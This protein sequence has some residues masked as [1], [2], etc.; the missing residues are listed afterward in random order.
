[1]HH[2]FDAGHFIALGLASA[3]L[4]GVYRRW[5]TTRPRTK[6]VALAV[7]S[8]ALGSLLLPPDLSNMAQRIGG[9]Y[10]SIAQKILLA[11]STFAITLGVP[12]AHALGRLLARPWWRWLGMAMGGAI[13]ATH[14]RVLSEFYH[15]IHFW[16][17]AT[18]VTFFASA[19]AGAVLP[20]TLARVLANCTGPRIR[21]V[22]LAFLSV[23]AAISIGH[24]PP[25]AVAM[26]LVRNDGS[27]LP[28]FLF[29]LLHTPTALHKA[30]IPAEMK[31]WFEDRRNH[32]PVAPTTPPFM[33]DKPIVILATIDCARADIILSGKYDAQLPTLARLRDISTTFTHARATAS[34]TAS[35][36]AS[37][38]MGTYF[39]QQYWAPAK[40]RLE[41]YAE[42]SPRVPEI[43][44]GA[45]V[46][47]VT[48][49]GA[50]GLTPRFGVLRGFSESTNLQK[51]SRY[52]KAEELMT[53]ALARLKNR[54]N[55]ALFLYLHFLDAHAPYDRG[56]KTG[57]L[58]D[59]YISE[60]QLVD[61]Q[62]SR[63]VWHIQSTPLRDRTLLIVTADHGE[64]FGEHNTYFHSST[65]YDELLHVPLLI[66]RPG[67]T[68]FVANEPVS[69]I[70]LGPTILDAFGVPTP[71]H[72]MGQSLVPFLRG[73]NPKL[74]RPILAEARLK[75]A[76]ILPDGHK[77]IVD[78]RL[79]TVELY[80]LTTD[81][82]EI[83]SLADDEERLLRPLSLLQ[84]FFQ[85]HT[86]RTPGY[87]PPYRVW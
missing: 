77:V 36:L 52:A 64:A 26:A 9:P 31:P 86:N 38:F 68:P 23:C 57:S 32:E 12:I 43:L 69:L 4:C 55:G 34:G 21:N 22:M 83:T 70:D 72:F 30:E 50:P 19:L 1:M 74:T 78:N 15:G 39:S 51:D 44:N 29:Q 8:C 82:G 47:T 73:D 3:G 56:I 6:Y 81:P 13:V 20:I 79:H 42:N 49:T 61:Q 18:A 63:L 24:R 80:N 54:S 59:R 48:Y 67:S 27:L 41:L 14:A 65:I 37:I 45:S 62:L 58:F 75:Q 76:L 2:A 28:H 53:P 25:S 35:S 71:G 11:A 85:V 5:G 17:V 84:Q 66:W 46:K 40:D 33:P 60:L 16:I 10:G 87:T 7:V